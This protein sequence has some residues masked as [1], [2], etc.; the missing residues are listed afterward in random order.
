MEEQ[1]VVEGED[2]LKDIPFGK[3]FGEEDDDKENF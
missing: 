3:N 1:D 2:D